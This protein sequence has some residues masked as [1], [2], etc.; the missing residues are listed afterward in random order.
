MAMG[1]RYRY[2]LTGQ[3]QGVGFRPFVHRIATEAGVT[4]WVLNDSHGVELEVQGRGEQMELFHERLMHDL[5]RL[6]RIET[7]Q[8]KRVAASGEERS[9][10]IKPSRGGGDADAAVTVDTAMCAECRE[11]LFR[12]T[13]RRHLHAFI[14]CTQCGPRYSIIR[15]IPYDRPNTSMRGFAMCLRCGAE[16]RDGGNRRFHAQPNCCPECGPAATLVD[17]RGKV[18]GGDPLQIAARMLIAGKIVAVKGIGGFHLA[19]R[20][21]DQEA[22]G[23]L[24]RLKHRDSKPFALMVKDVAD[25]RELVGLSVGAVDALESAASPIVLARRRRGSEKFVAEAVAPGTHLLGVMLPA[26]PIQHLLFHHLA[27]L[28]TEAPRALVMTSGNLASEPIAIDDADAIQRLGG[29]CDGLVVHD[30]GIE[31]CVDDSVLLDRGPLLAPMPVRRSRGYV[32]RAWPIPPGPGGH[33]TG[34]CVGGELKNT[35]ALVRQHDVIVSQHLGDLMHPLAFE[36]FQ[37]AIADLTRLFSVKIEFVAHDLHPGYVSTGYARELARRHGAKLIPIQH[38]LAH[39]HGVLAEHRVSEAM[40]L[41]C[42]GAG[43]GTDGT[44]WGGEVLCVRGTRWER[45]G[46]LRPMRL[47]GG[48]AAARDGRRSAAALLYQAFGEAFEGMEIAARI[49]P[50]GE[51]RKSILRM[52]RSGFQS[53]WTTSTGRLFDGVAALLGVCDRNGHESQAAM[54]LEAAAAGAACDVEA[55]LSACFDVARDESGLWQLDLSP[56]VRRVAACDERGVNAR[57]LAAEFHLALAQGFAA[58]V[59]A[60]DGAELPLAVSGGTFCNQVFTGHLQRILSRHQRR[61]LVPNEYP[62]TDAGLSF[63]Q[64]GYVLAA[65]REAT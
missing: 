6:A 47:P 44:T 63:G 11:E 22:V 28:C 55:D 17:A 43:H 31:R 10:V 50:C 57:R 52:M 7:M 4:G 38:H 2:R 19:V 59:G 9:F 15:D 23:R 3:L 48:D 62:P 34:V 45:V 8:R 18:L 26:T 53:P 36:H 64:A 35:V 61:L 39:A 32:P 58:L 60:A 12:E 16:Y 40:A 25:A 65:A 51:E 13:D 42:D 1:Q 27:T 33:A 20:A 29:I 24:R 54:A 56:F 14:N 49:W 5:P 41:V 37:K 21:D 46:H 30:R